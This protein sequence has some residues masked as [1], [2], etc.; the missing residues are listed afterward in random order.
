ML[1]NIKNLYLKI[2]L[3]VCFFIIFS[4]SF[5]YSASYN[6]NS[7]FTGDW[8]D[9]TN[10]DIA[11]YPGN[12]SNDQAII[13]NGNAIINSGNHIDMSSGGSA[14]IGNSAGT[15]GNLLINDA[16]MD[17]TNWYIAWNGTGNVTLNGGNLIAG[18]AINLGYASAG[19][20]YLIHNSGNITGSLYVGTSGYGY[21]ELNGGFFSSSSHLYVGH[22]SGASANLVMNSGNIDI[23]SNRL[24]VGNNG[25]ALH[26]QNG[27]NMIID[28]MYVGYLSSDASYIQNGGDVNVARLYVGQE[29]GASGYFEMNGGEF[30]SSS[31]MPLGGQSGGTGNMVITGGNIK[32]DNTFSVGASGNGFLRI[33]GG[34]LHTSNFYHGASSTS[35]GVTYQTGGNIESG[36]LVLG[37]SG[38]YGEYNFSGGN[39]SPSRIYVGYTSTGIGNLNISGVGNLHMGGER[40]YLGYD[41]P[42]CLNM[43]GGNVGLYRAFIGSNSAHGDFYMSGGNYSSYN[44][45]H[46]G[47]D[48]NSSGNLVMSGGNYRCNNDTMVG[49]DGLA[50]LTLSGGNMVLSNTYVGYQGSG[51]LYVN[52]GYFSADT[53]LIGQ[54]S[55]A[56]GNVVFNEGI[57]NVGQIEIADNGTGRLE[58]NGSN[59]TAATIKLLSSAATFRI[60]GPSANVMC[61]RYQ[62][63]TNDGYFECVLST[64]NGHFTAMTCT[65]V[66]DMH[67]NLKIGLDGGV[68]MAS[69]N[70]FDLMVGEGDAGN[71]YASTPS[72]WDINLITNAYGTKEAVRTSLA[73]GN[74]LAALDMNGTSNT[75]VSSLSAGYVTIANIDTSSSPL[76]ID[77]LLDVQSGTASTVVEKLKEAGYDASLSSIGVYD[78]S[79]II[80][81]SDLAS[82][83]GYFVWDL[84]DITSGVSYSYVDNV[85]VQ[86]PS[87]GTL[88]RFE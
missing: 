52:D 55:G 63:S 22:I 37:I 28:R 82:G 69:S 30:Y 41:G 25:S 45:T 23:A 15:S 80:A 35:R 38:G 47:V 27:G 40:L 26:T 13:N 9:T 10:W 57:I 71:S 29:N 87:Y 7:G 53:V 77:V 85:K 44:Y 43:S 21:Y 5:V 83:T 81:Q 39:L 75:S 3:L 11:N 24:Y 42:G 2:L 62:N 88:F 32:T 1:L 79:I 12:A 74:L 49:K 73:A 48:A 31:I 6:W 19:R 20:G 46:I 65:S 84:R 66:V 34:N 54:L 16:Y 59:I 60:N 72:M 36:Y 61:T 8:T 67:G 4:I 14:L 50:E 58:A 56:S 18:T 86:L 33:S 64:N 68:L 76:G 70:T 17:T 51:N 78:V